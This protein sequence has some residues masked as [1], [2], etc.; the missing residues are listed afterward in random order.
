M[1]IYDI[2]IS[3]VNPQNFIHDIHICMCFN[4]SP[5][6]LFSSFGLENSLRYHCFV[7]CYKFLIFTPPPPPQKI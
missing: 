2:Y 5:L 6:F 3:T 1:K 7:L 4:C